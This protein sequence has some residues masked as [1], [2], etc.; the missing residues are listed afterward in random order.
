M[1]VI[2]LVAVV[3]MLVVVTCSVGDGVGGCS[4]IDGC[5]VRD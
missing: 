2:V 5:G 4:D 3:V 1:L